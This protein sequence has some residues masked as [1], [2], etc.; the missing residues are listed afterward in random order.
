MAEPFKN[1]FSESLIRKLAK[2]ILEEAKGFPEKKFLKAALKDLDSLELKE[3]VKR[4]AE[5]LGEH[6]P[7]S[8]R[9]N[10]LILL[11]VKSALGS[12]PGI[13]FP[14]YVALFGVNDKDFDFSLSALEE[15]T[16]GSSAEFGIRPFIEFDPNRAMKH[17]ERFAKSQDEEVRRLSSEGIRPRLPWGGNLQCFIEDPLPILAILETLLDDSSQYVRKSVA[18]NLNDI[19]K[20][21]PDLVVSFIEEHIGR[22]KDSDWIL[23]RGA[24]TLLK[25]KN[26]RAM[27]FFGYAKG[28]AVAK[29]LES[30]SFS[31]SPKVLHLG[32]AL[33]ASFCLKFTK[34]LR[35]RLRLEYRVMHMAKNNLK[36]GKLFFFKEMTVGASGCLTGKKRIRFKDYSIRKQTLGAHKLLF[37]L[38]GLELEGDTDFKIVGGKG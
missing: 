14:A 4:I 34:Q 25:N 15:F 10:V 8:F 21:N 26:K 2:R 16:K 19:S 23:E 12:L 36:S 37:F 17:V 5:A 3:R 32:D 30:A 6:M 9:E 13:V 27:D 24:R 35:G 20:D 11:K 29:S 18:N 33:E 22:G 28:A 38:N 7:G 31:V 1:R